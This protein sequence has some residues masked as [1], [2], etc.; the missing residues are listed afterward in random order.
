MDALKFVVKTLVIGALLV[1]L[2]GCGVVSLLTYQWL[3]PAPSAAQAAVIVEK[4]VEKPTIVEK[5]DPAPKRN[6]EGSEHVCHY[7]E[8]YTS[9]G[10]TVPAGTLVTGPAVVKPNRNIDW[11]YPVYPNEEYTTRNSDETV[12][13]LVGDSACVDAQEGNEERTFFSYWGK[14]QTSTK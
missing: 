14:T 6:N 2:M 1:G 7:A 3:A 8:G 9:E 13:L 5:D 10:R 4:P 11:G 12:W